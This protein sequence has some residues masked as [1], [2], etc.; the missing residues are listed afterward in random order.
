VTDLTAFLQKRPTSPLAPEAAF[1]IGDARRLEGKR[2]EAMGAFVEFG[3]RYASHPRAGEALF[4][5]A[6]LT[7]SAPRAGSVEE[8]RSLFAE[9]AEKHRESP[10]APA[11]L[12]EK[13]SIE[14]RLKLRQI[15]LALQTSVPAS[16]VTRRT[17][18]ERYPGHQLSEA[19][20]W[21]LADA[22]EAANRFQHAADALEKLAATFP[23]TKYDAAFRA[24]EIF[25]RRLKDK[26]RARAAYL[27][28][29]VTSPRYKDAQKRGGVR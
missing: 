2:D 6:Q 23:A 11:A 29:P 3:A 21:S 24:A 28:V 22:Y 10:W 25:E 9:A 1:L 20:Y 5:L 15:D 13:A 16:L 26:E 14:D 18:V 4:R 12:V 8:A 27:K 19:A 7:Q 17:L